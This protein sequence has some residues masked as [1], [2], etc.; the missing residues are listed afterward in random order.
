MLCC[1]FNCQ[2]I[3]PSETK[4]QLIDMLSASGLPVIEATSF[5]SPKWVPQVGLLLPIISFTFPLH[6][7]LAC[8]KTTT[9]KSEGLEGLFFCTN[10]LLFYLLDGRSGGGNE[11]DQS[12]TRGILPS[13]HAQPQGFPGCSEYET[14]FSS[15]LPK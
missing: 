10:M 11:G 7:T 12:K 5:V 2:T 9:F 14:I 3:V 1:C 15:T 6:H 4:I 13:P 8:T